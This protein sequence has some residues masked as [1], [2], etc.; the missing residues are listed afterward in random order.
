MWTAEVSL[1]N[2]GI[3][4]NVNK[5]FTLGFVGVDRIPTHLDFHTTIF[6]KYG[7]LC[8]QV[9]NSSDE[10]IMQVQKA[11]MILTRNYSLFKNANGMEAH[12]SEHDA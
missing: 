8:S 6:V 5:A 9:V 4:S 3:V 10:P 7:R 11:K 12:N 2:K 1:S